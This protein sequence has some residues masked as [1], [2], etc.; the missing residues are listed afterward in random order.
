MTS[1]FPVGMVALIHL[2][3]LVVAMMLWQTPRGR[4]TFGTTPEIA[5]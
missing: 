2:G 3:I 4:R 1:V 5:V